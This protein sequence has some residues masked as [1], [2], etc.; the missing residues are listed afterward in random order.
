MIVFTWLSGLL[1][2]RRGRLVASTIGVAIAVGLLATI[3]AFLSAS[4]STMTERASKSVSTDWQVE[5]KPGGDASVAAAVADTVK[6]FPGLGR[7]T[8]VTFGQTTGFELTKDGSTQTTGPGVVVGLPDSYNSSFPD[9]FRTLSGADTGVRLAQQT[10]A[11]LHASPGDMIKI[12]RNG[13]PPI[14]VQVDGIVDLPGADSFFQKVGTTAQATAPPDNVLIVAPTLWMTLYGPIA[15]TRPDLVTTQFHADFT[16]HLPADPSAA[17]GKVIGEA[18]NLELKLAGTGLVADNLGAELAKAR[19]DALYAQVLFLFLGVPGTILAGLLTATVS[20]SGADRRRRDQALLRTRG[21]TTRQLVEVG[22]GETAFVTVVGAAAGLLVAFAIGAISFGSA[23]FGASAISLGLWSIGAIAAGAIISGLSIAWPAYRDARQLT[24]AAARRSVGRAQNPRWLRWRLD[25]ITLALAA[26]VYWATSRNGFRLV[27]AVEGIPQISVN[28]WAFA[29]PALAWIGGALMLWRIANTV[30]ARGQGVV[31]AFIRP[32]SGGLSGTVAASMRRQ[33]RLLARG[34]TLVA[35]TTAFAASTS[36]FNSTYKH[37]AEVDAVLSNGAMVSVVESP[38]IVVDPSKAAEFRTIAG[39]RSVT[40]LQHRFAYVGA[41]LQDLYG[42]D[43]KTIVKSTKLQD[44]YF[45][46]GTAKQLMAKLAARPDAVLVSSET[47]KDFQLSPG[48]LIKLRLQD[49]RTKQYEPVAFTYVGVALEFPSAPRDSFLV[50]NAKYVARMT[51][52]NAIARFLID[53]A[54]G[55]SASVAA[56]VQTLVGTDALVSDIALTRQ[57]IGTDLT[58][59]ELKGLTKVELGFALLLAAAASGLVLWLGLSE[60]R[61]TFAIASALGAK[62]RQLGGFV[63]SEAA[64][65][66]V[67]GA[68]LGALGGWILTAMLVKILTGVFDPAPSSLTVP[69]GYLSLVLAIA[70]ASVVIAAS[71]AVRATRRPTIDML[72]DL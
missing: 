11:N 44:A 15:T 42:V 24:V 45:Q 12:G 50:A 16:Q 37:Q 59:V 64:F 71:T 7:V 1:R 29:A 34:L 46:G 55:D 21:A 25:F 51:R 61:R 41:D 35:L 33:R 28:Y 53:T 48:D 57:K 52:S 2:R 30:L 19:S 4:K 23:T 40:S 8:K 22:L 32:L 60:R 43:A 17:Y 62:P 26:A 68:L 65:V 39:V 31:K 72:R 63:W 10:A 67:G 20:A 14:E 38:G 27:L 13:E 70:L 3:G 69:W 47:V 6:E 5:V 36:V 54:P 9:T 49:G 18:H 56:R 58:A 66:T